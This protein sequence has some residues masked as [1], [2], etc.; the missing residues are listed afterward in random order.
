M[1]TD[2]STRRS[3]DSS[4]LASQR[5][6]QA[7][8]HFGEPTTLPTLRGASEYSF[9]GGLKRSFTAPSLSPLEETHGVYPIF[10][11]HVFDY[12]TVTLERHPK[13]AIAMLHSVTKKSKLTEEEL[14]KMLKV[15]EGLIQLNE[16]FT[17]VHDLRQMVA[18]SRKQM[19]VVLDW[20]AGHRQ[21]LDI[22]IQ[23]QRVEPPIS[24]YPVSV[25]LQLL[26]HSRA[27]SL[28]LQSALCP[29]P[30]EGTSRLA[31]SPV[32]LYGTSHSA[33]HPAPLKGI[34]VILS[35]PA[36][37]V[38]VNFL[39]GVIKPPQPIQIVKDE[40]AAIKFLSANCQIVQPWRQKY[41]E[42]KGK[43]QGVPTTPSTPQRLR[44]AQQA[45]A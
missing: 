7:S 20:L 9:R 31:S 45:L 39:L 18:P 30:F 41:E 27:V 12:A 14:G 15:A 25:D 42:R 2:E 36:I 19:R 28:L 4:Q 24:Q 1:Q 40:E 17:V 16:Y 32:S 33:S 37:R 26:V 8:R 29:V 3:S 5:I 43:R 10:G 23:V 13:L 44:D 6:S 11:P 22:L 21:H 38:L 34:V 35:N